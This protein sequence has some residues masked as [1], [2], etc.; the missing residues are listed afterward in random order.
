VGIHVVAGLKKGELV[1]LFV[2]PFHNAIFSGKM[3]PLDEIDFV[4]FQRTLLDRSTSDPNRYYSD[5][6]SLVRLQE[7][8]S[9]FSFTRLDQLRGRHIIY[10]AGILYN[11][12][13]VIVIGS[14]LLTV[15]LAVLFVR[16]TLLRQR[17]R[18]R[19]A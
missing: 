10:A 13:P 8:L 15:T 17:N 18:K 2:V 6:S 11:H 3:G 7:V 9:R 19:E 16:W 12:Y 5:P 1:Q 14:G 4:S